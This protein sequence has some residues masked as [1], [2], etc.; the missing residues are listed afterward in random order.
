MTETH[1]G[2]TTDLLIIEYHAVE[3]VGS[4]EHLRTERGRDELCCAGKVL[5]HVW[6][7]V[8]HGQHLL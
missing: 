3:L 1:R 8:E 6:N 5:D 4:F 2:N 7:I